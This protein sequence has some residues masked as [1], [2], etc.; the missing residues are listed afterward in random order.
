MKVNKVK[1]TIISCLSNVTLPMI[2][3]CVHYLYN[4]Q[5]LV[6]TSVNLHIKDVTLSDL[7][8][9]QHGKYIFNVQLFI[10]T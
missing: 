2:Q 10:S 6:K 9:P 3:Y 7:L 1:E 8:S 4:K 5:M